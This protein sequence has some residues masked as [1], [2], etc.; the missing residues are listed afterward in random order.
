MLGFMSLL[1]GH[2]PMN[3]FKIYTVFFNNNVITLLLNYFYDDYVI[4]NEDYTTL[5]YVLVNMLIFQNVQYFLSQLF[6]SEKRIEAI[7]YSG[8]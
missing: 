3:I 5:H 6:R 8:W 1:L 7:R 4:E 2:E